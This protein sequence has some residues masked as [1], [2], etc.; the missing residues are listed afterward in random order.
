MTITTWSHKVDATIDLA[1][2]KELLLRTCGHSFE[3]EREQALLA[4][5]GRRMSALAIST[6]ESYHN[7]LLSDQDELLRL[8]ELLTVNETYFYR[9]PDHLKLIV[10]M[11]LP[12]FMAAGN[13]RP[14]RILS[15][16]CSTG[17]EPYSIAIMLR[18]RF[19]TESERLFAITGVDIDSGAI[20]SAKQGVY[21]KSSFRG[22]DNSLQERYFEADAQGKFQVTAS[23]RKQVSFE[24]VNLLD[25]AYPY[26]MQLS[27]IILYRNVS[28]YFPGQV[29]REIFAKLAGHLSD[30]GCLLVGASETFHH[31]IGILSLVK[32]ASLFFYRKIPAPVIKERRTSSRTFGVSEPSRGG[33]LQTAARCA[34]RLEVQGAGV[35]ERH[36]SERPRTPVTSTNPDMR[37]YF[38]TAVQLAHDKQCDKALA[39]LDTIIEQD[40]TFEKA[41]C[42]K[43]GVLLDMSRFDE[44]SIIFDSV[45]SRDP[46]CLEAYLV[47]GIIARQRGNNEYALK[48]FREA[49]YLNASCWLAH[50]YSAEINYANNDEKRARGHYETTLRILENGSP[51]KHGQDF[52]PLS[53]NAEQFLVICRH[54]LSLLIPSRCTEDWRVNAALKGK[55]WH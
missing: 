34:T 10:T 50:F 6:C 22:M 29:Q 51:E 33:Q 3:Q 2:I 20:A 5:L 12:E 45:L 48:R 7:R 9:E 35:Q 26:R 23:I 4:G 39:I 11:L 18:E 40:T 47:L 28:I 27:D 54:K 17:E 30:G 55:T 24:V 52:F 8:T 43:G 1:P 19:G 32:E 15:A 42:L 14:V 46:L 49:I 44:A 37:E 38:D 53:F 13:Q 36:I 25:S 16:G 31:D 41:Y 21:G